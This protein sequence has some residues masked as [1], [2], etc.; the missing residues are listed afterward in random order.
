MHA[1][2]KQNKKAEEKRLEAE[3]VKAAKELKKAE[4]KA[5]KNNKQ[6]ETH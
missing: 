4:D 6:M 1:E 5:G 2:E 3:I